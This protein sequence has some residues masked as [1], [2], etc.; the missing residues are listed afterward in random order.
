MMRRVALAGL[1]VALGLCAGPVLPART[2]AIDLPA[3]L[4]DQQFWDLTESLSEEGG[5]F[6]SDN[7]VS[8][9]AQYQ[10]VVPDLLKRTRPG[11][12]YIGV[13]PEQ[14]FTYIAALRPKMVFILD[15]RR[16]NLHEHLLYKALMEMSADRAEFLSR[17]FSRQRPAGLSQ[18]TRVEDLFAAYAG[19]PGT[20]ARYRANLAAVLAWLTTRHGF[21]L[22]PGDADGID[23][24][25]RNAF[26]VDGPD[27]GY[28]LTGRGRV[29]SPAYG[30]LMALDDGQGTQRSYLS[31]ESAFG[32]V[33]D[34][35]SRNLIVPVVGDFGG[36]KAL[37]G[38]GRYVRD[39]RATVTAFYLS[40]V[41]QYLQGASRVA[42]CANLQTMPFD[43][44]STF[45]RS[46]R[47][48]RNTGGSMFASSLGQIQDEMRTCVANG[49]RLQPG[50]VRMTR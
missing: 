42:F 39:Q 5:T 26:F 6:H 12:L 32:V 17:L 49:N 21:A 25:Y 13:G 46:V 40:N 16:G 33:K 50:F 41:E 38:I 45:I 27:L 3:R 48:G 15:I 4:T 19:L 18:A 2:T 35:Q 24:V 23:Y 1:L 47:G 31:S 28:A 37:R 22:R 44:S 36:P 43:V 10:F 29:G 14:N 8:N 7:F 34:L 11:G 30:E 9:E 20:E